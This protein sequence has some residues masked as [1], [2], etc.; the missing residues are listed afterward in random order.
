MRLVNHLEAIYHEEGRAVPDGNGG[1]DYEYAIRDHLGSTRVMFQMINGT[2][3][4]VQ[5]S[6]TYPFGMELNGPAFVGG[7]NP[8]R[9]TGKELETD[10]E[11]GLYDYGARWYDPAAGRWWGVDAMAEKFFSQS[12]FHFSGNNPVR[13][14][15][16]DGNWYG[17]IYNLN[18][19]WIGSD[20]K[21]DNK[22]YVKLTASDSELSVE[23]AKT[24]VAKTYITLM[25]NQCDVIDLTESMGI[26]HDDFEKFAANIHNETSGMSQD[27]KEDVASAMTNRM[28]ALGQDMETMTDKLMFWND[29]H[30]KKMSETDRKPGNEEKYGDNEFT[31]Q[32]VSTAQYRNFMN[33]SKQDRNSNEAMKGAV[34]ATV[35]QAINPTDRV[36]GKYNWRGDGIRHRFIG[37]AIKKK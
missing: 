16:Y 27:D 20:G 6:H 11:I 21:N 25:C 13:F 24:E 12:T 2:A 17:D 36:N 37:P 34:K 30:E 7:G 3:T 8:Y 15:D 35:N 22:V 9:Y 1:Y 32:D 31:H 28:E 29:N 26:Q 4:I 23:E 19:T 14:I 5:E 10:L 18:G 33:S